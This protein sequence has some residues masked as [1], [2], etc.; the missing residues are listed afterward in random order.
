[1]IQHCT[2][3]AREAVES[4]V[5]LPEE[6]GYQAA[7]E[8][9][10][11][12]FGKPHMIAK[13]HIK[14][15]ENLVPLRQVDGQSLLE[16]VRHLEVAVRTFAGMGSEYTEELNHINTLK[17]MNR[18]LPVFMR[19]KWMEKAGEI[20]ESGSRPK[21]QDFLEFVKRRAAL[22]NNE[23]GEDIANFSPERNGGSKNNRYV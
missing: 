16:F 10:R 5:N 9:L 23:F 4:C 6:E 18:K 17:M 12:N 8:T 20:I 3:K 13:A 2:G 15:L 1:M 14:K 21:F 19:I 11:E 7:K 22:V